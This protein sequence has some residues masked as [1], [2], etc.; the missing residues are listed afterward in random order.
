MSIR[1]ARYGLALLVGL[2]LVL[3]SVT[4][5]AAATTLYVDRGSATCSN[6]GSGTQAAPFCTISAAALKAVAGTTVQVSPGTYTEMVTVKNSGT[7]SA[8]VVFTAPGGATVT[9]G[10]NGFKLGSKAYVTVQGF[11]VTKTSGVGILVSGSNHITLDGN[12]VS[13]AGQRVSGLV[14]KGISLSGSTA[15]VVRNNRTHDNSDAGIGLTSAS[16]GNTV[17][18]NESWGNARGFSRAAAGI[19]LRNSTGNTV[20]ANRLHDNEDS[21][22][23]IWNGSSGTLAVNNVIWTNGDHGIDVHSTND[24]R[25]VSNTVYKNYDSGIEMTGSLRT[26]LQNNISADNGIAS[27]RTSGQIRTDATSAP[28]TTLDYDLLWLSVTPTSNTVFIHWAGTKYKTLAAF[29]SA[30]G[31]EMHG[32]SANPLFVNPPGDLHLQA[33]SPAIGRANQGA[34]GEP[35]VDADGKARSAPYDI[36]AYEA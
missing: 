18:G 13:V 35:S 24:A 22:L 14:A 11:T 29:Q 25:V 4:P 36:G 3:L 2:G 17:S 16:N 5:A 30:T 28:S 12:D 19:D 21:G 32:V 34:P 8:P 15:S 10:T 7:A 1:T 33:G 23:N 9:G 6:T 20:I 27:A 26:Y 31:Q